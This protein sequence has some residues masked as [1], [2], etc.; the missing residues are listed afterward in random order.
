MVNEHDKNWWVQLVNMRT[1][2]VDLG[3]P[4]RFAVWEMLHKDQK[5][6]FLY[7]C[8]RVVSTKL[9]QMLKQEESSGAEML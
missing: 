2:G 5:N 6:S 4:D 3:S 7:G 1:A 9:I 8:K